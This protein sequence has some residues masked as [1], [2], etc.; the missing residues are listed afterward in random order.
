ME[1]TPLEEYGA[2]GDGNTVALSGADG[3]IDWWPAPH[4]ESSS[5]FAAVLDADRGGRF[6]VRPTASFESVQRYRDRTNV[7]ETTFRTAGGAA[8]LT[9]FV[10]VAEAG[11]SADRPPA[12]YRKLDCEEGPLEVS[13]TFEPRFDYARDVPRIE[14][15]A[16]GV[17]A[18]G[19]DERAVL[20][21]DLALEVTSGDAG[22]V[23]SDEDG[24]EPDD[25]TKTGTAA[26]AT[27]TLEPGE[28]RWF[29]LGYGEA[30]PLEPSR[31]RETL[32]E[33]V[34]YWR[35]WTHDC[36]GGDCPVAGPWH[37]LAVRSSLVLKLLIHRETG[38]V[39]AAPTTSLPEDIGGVRNWDYRYNWI[40]DA[41]FTVRA[42]S[43]LDHLEEARSYFEL[44]LDHCSRH[45]PAEMPPVYSLHGGSDFEERVLDHLE[46]YRGSAPVRVG[47][48]ARDQHQLDVYGELVL[49]LYESVRYGEPMRSDDWPVVRDLVDY[50]VEGWDEPDAG[51]WEVRT[52]PEHF[53]YSK[54]MCWTALDRGIELAEAADGVDAPLERWRTARDDV[55]AAILERGVSEETNSFVQSF[56]DADTLDAANL[57]VPVVGFL[58]PDDDRVRRTIDAT[59]D[60]LATDD[61]LVRRYEGDDGLPGVDNPFVVSAFW[62]VTA[63]ALAG[64]TDEARER[65]ESILE[66]ASPLGLL[67]EAVDPDD[68]E[69]RGNYPQAYSHIGLLNGA[70]YLTDATGSSDPSPAPLGTDGARDVDSSTTIV[71]R[72]ND[73][74]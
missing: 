66:Y 7:L 11:E 31:H 14:P 3:S 72:S 63:L 20:S 41:A 65:F 46:G 21:S 56:G 30:I 71:G 4:V 17:V 26:T 22:D 62:L 44:C 70:L 13:A 29:V 19:D 8:T 57:L 9:D 53:V 25:G 2:I 50:V 54:V 1:Y 27:A 42:L 67:G 12:I 36:D 52:D 59:I 39:C 16:D 60:R 24:I 23:G 28:T 74:E 64:R 61:G 68:G 69:Q 6:A 18:T 48:A 45:D 34:D 38:A 32:A 33:T 55:R 40:R 49:A 51:I 73:N 43:E 15:T 37:D 47:N 58:P 5:V 35:S 10:P